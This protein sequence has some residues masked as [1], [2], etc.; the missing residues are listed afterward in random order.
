MG[1]ESGLTPENPAI[2]GAGLIQSMTITF[3]IDMGSN[4]PHLAKS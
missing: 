2:D 4:S 3:I 1:K